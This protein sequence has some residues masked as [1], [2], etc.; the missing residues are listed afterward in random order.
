MVTRL[1]V[2]M[3]LTIETTRPTSN[4]VL[5]PV[6]ELWAPALRARAQ[7]WGLYDQI[8]AV[9]GDI[10]QAAAEHGQGVQPAVADRPTSGSPAEDLFA[11]HREVV[12]EVSQLADERQ[13]TRRLK[14]DIGDL[15]DRRR[16]VTSMLLS[17]FVAAA[18]VVGIVLVLTVR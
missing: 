13:E 2:W 14:S 9:E 5:P 18:S 12:R 17:L 15:V 3:T 11:L 1:P 7:L 10:T 4:D 6:P 16:R 8:E